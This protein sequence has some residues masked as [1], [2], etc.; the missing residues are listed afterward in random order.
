MQKSSLN[1]ERHL[2]WGRSVSAR[3]IA[4]GTNGLDATLGFVEEAVGWLNAWPTRFAIVRKP[5]VVFACVAE[6]EKDNRFG[7]RGWLAPGFPALTLR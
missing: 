1:V 2:P 4:D 3:R 6:I 7:R 5:L